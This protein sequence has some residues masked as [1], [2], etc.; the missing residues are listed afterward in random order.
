MK[1]LADTHIFL[2]AL[3]SPEKIPARTRKLMRSPENSVFVSVIT[4]WEIS[5]KYALGR[6]ELRGVEPHELPAFASQMDF[7]LLGLSAEDAA[8]FCQLP[9]LPHKDPFDRMIV[10]QALRNRMTLM[11][12]DEGLVAYE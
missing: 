2:W 5:L 4:F 3:F 10:W 12:K 11:T 9:R 8:S 1:Y 7:E 6:L